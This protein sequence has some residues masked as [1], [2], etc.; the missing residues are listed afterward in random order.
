[1]SVLPLYSWTC[2]RRSTVSPHRHLVAKLEAY[3][4]FTGAVDLL[5]SY[6]S[7]RKQQVRLGPNRSTRKNLFKGVPQGSILE[8]LLFNIFINNIFYFVV[9]SFI[10]PYADDNTVSFIHKDLHVLKNV[11]QQESIFLIKWFEIT[12]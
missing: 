6:L 4:L 9:Q 2:P 8:P 5:D 1:M 7:G 12:I 11:L 3:G 10:Y